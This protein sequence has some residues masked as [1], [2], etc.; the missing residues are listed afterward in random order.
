MSIENAD[1]PSATPVRKFPSTGMRVL[2][3]V[4][5]GTAILWW[6]V[7]KYRQASADALVRERCAK[8]G[9]IR[10]YEL[11]RLPGDRFNEYGEVRV[12]ELDGRE[13]NVDFFYT[14]DDR[15][16]VREGAGIGDLDVRRIHYRLLRARDNKLI[17]ESIHYSRRGGDPIGPWHPSSFNCP[18][19]SGIKYLVQ[20]AFAKQ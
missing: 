18:E 15:W 10:V 4:L 14:V 5:L 3:G 11:V 16:I 7:P 17:G 20:Q 2:L 12:R 13:K 9:G 1:K 8:D 19:N 6:G